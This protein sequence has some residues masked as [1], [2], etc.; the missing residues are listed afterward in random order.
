MKNLVCQKFVCLPSECPPLS[1]SP[2]ETGGRRKQNRNFFKV[3]NAKSFIQNKY[4]GLGAKYL[5]SSRLSPSAPGPLTPA[6]TGAAGARPGRPCTG[7][8]PRDG[9]STAARAR[10]RRGKGRGGVPALRLAVHAAPAL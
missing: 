2:Y 7:T 4:R 9:T 10:P 6:A 3:S 5:S 8:F 1:E